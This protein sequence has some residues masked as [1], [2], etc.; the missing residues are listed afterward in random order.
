M[1]VCDNTGKLKQKF[2]R[3][4]GYLR[5][6]S[7]TGRNEIMILSDDTAAMR[8]YSEEGNLKSTIELPESDEVIGVAY[9]YVISKIIVLSYSVK[10]DSFVIRCH[11]E[12]GEL[13]PTMFV[14][15]RENNERPKITCHPN[16]P[17]AVVTE[18][19]ITFI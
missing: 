9:H 12:T 17:G 18:Q 2:E 14:C 5:S 3:D 16:G 11:T 4:T 1:Y 19:R 15:K 7:I 8:I 13:E 10:N 6:L